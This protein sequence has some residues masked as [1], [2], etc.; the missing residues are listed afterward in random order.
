MTK[1]QP[2]R[3]EVLLARQ[4]YSDNMGYTTTIMHPS[5]EEWEQFNGLKGRRFM[6]VAVM[7]ADDDQPVS[8][9]PV[10]KQPKEKLGPKAMWVVQNCADPRFQKFLGVDG[11]SNAREQVL[12]EFGVESRREIDDIH[13][14][15]TF[16]DMRHEYAAWLQQQELS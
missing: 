7:L 15:K 13:Y 5:R 6:M 14:A 9:P 11:E 2:W 1:D 10:V 8:A 3:G 16:D 4:S 12:L